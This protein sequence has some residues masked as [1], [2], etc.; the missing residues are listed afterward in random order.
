MFERLTDRARRVLVLAQEEARILNHN[1]FGTEHILLGLIR[2]GG[3]VAAKALE[4]SNV[5][6]CDVRKQVL[7]NVEE[8]QLTS[9]G[10]IP[11]TSPAKSV[12]KFSR[13]EAR[14]LGHKHIGTEHILLGLIRGGD[15]AA[16]QIL[17]KLGV[18]PNKVRQ[19]IIRILAGYQGD[20]D[21]G[22]D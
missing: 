14:M 3:G 20:S 21:D 5:H 19:Q 22:E 17:V 9:D 18:D 10:S 6:L 16:V 2:E 4:T 11:F 1:G 12:M 8:G 13:S 7:A 15:S